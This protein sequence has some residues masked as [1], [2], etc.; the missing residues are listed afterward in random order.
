[1]SQNRRIKL[2]VEYDG[3][4]YHG[5]QRQRECDSVQQRIETAIERITGVYPNVQVAGRTDA[6]V[7]GL[8]QVCHFDTASSC[9]LLAFKTGINSLTPASITILKA[10]E[11]DD[12]FHARYSATRREYE[13]LLYCRREPSPHWRNRAVHIHC[14]LD[15]DAMRRAAQS[16]CGEHDFSAF[17][18]SECSSSTPLCNIEFITLTQDGPLLK[19]H[20]KGDHFLHNMVRIITGTLVDIGKGK[21]PENTT[22]K[23][24]E[25]LNRAD[26]GATIPPHGLYFLKVHHKDHEIIADT[27]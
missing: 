24:L 23:M 1:M 7:H 14:P 12:T 18:T 2:T 21:L 25:T 15:V 22:R 9:Q 10:E 4:P 17:R 11:V 16:L 13:F 20:I 5:W 3:T 19:L 8:A 26:G 27:E 6:G